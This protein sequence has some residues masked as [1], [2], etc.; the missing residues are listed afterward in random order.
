MR[1][2][3][4]IVAFG[5]IALCLIVFGASLLIGP[6]GY[7]PFPLVPAPARVPV[8]LTIWYG[9]EKKEWM[10]AAS[11]RFLA[12]APAVNGR[13]IQIQLQGMGSREIADR[14]VQRDWRDQPPPTVVS[15]ASAL[16]LDAVNAP[17]VRSG[18]DAPRPLVLSPLVVVS[19][20]QRAQA[21]WP[22]PPA[23]FWN[24]LQ[25]ALANQQGWPALGGNAS[26]GPVKFGHTSPLTSNSGTQA[27]MLMAYSFAKKSSGLSV[28]D[29]NNPALAAW[30]DPIERS[31]LSFSD[32][33]GALMDDVV[34]A[35]P[36]KYDFAVVYENLA[37]QNMEAA[38]QRQ[39]Q[40]LR[41]FYPPATMLSDHPYAVVDGSWVQAD[42]RAAAA[43]FRDFLVGATAQALA[44]QYGFRPVDPN[45]S[46]AAADADN[47][48]TKYAANGVQ[49][50]IARQVEP[51]APEVL[52]ALLQLW[53]NRL[54]H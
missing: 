37:L 7:A 43:Q 13:P 17:I 1:R 3:S 10:E 39:G 28:A 35:G 5:Y 41:I 52:N 26:W 48:F 31:V 40:A 11:Q 23:D 44:R 38:R 15:P 2:L 18:A 19:W 12:S 50:S 32:S 29:V 34:R 21:L 49:A 20:E 25:A 4:R 33:T 51:P 9:S 46:I 8:V 16:W 53:E 47:P 36:A 45:V 6:L 24:S 42:Q 27:L 30:L 54:K 14:L 22:Q